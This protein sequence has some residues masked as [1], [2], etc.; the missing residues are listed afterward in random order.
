MMRMVCV[1]SG[2]VAIAAGLIVTQGRL[3]QAGRAHRKTSR[4]HATL[5]DGWG[6]WFFHGFAN[7]SKGVGVVTAL[8]QLAVWVV[9]GVGL[10]SLGL[11]V[12][13]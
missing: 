11:C 5:P 1:I 9:V 8:A 7:V 4:V 6:S 10:V 2:L 13:W 12:T 3:Q